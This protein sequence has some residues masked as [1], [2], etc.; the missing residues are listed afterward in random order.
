M[1]AV[2]ADGSVRT[3]SF[4]VSPLVFKNFCVR[5][6]GLAVDMTNID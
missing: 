6:D 3:V 4:S 5:N 2:L 1:V